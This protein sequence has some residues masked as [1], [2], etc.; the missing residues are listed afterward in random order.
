MI[1]IV[2]VANQLSPTSGE[3]NHKNGGHLREAH[4]SELAGVQMSFFWCF[5]CWC[6]GLT[7]H[8]CEV[9]C[10]DPSWVASSHHR[11][12][13]C[14]GWCHQV[15][16]SRHTCQWHFHLC[17]ASKTW[18]RPLRTFQNIWRSQT[19][20]NA[21]RRVQVWSVQLWLLKIKIYNFV[22]HLLLCF[23]YWINFHWNKLSMQWVGR[24]AW[25]AYSAICPVFTQ[26]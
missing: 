1:I 13:T 7:D 23:L 18:L 15:H 6:T 8:L 4:A 16:I 14:S 11:S 19:S 25:L 20:D 10:H 24:L 21:L 9:C 12:S 2:I 17:L 26:F 22:I 5:F 3:N